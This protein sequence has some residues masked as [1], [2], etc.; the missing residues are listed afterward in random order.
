MA[1]RALLKRRITRALV[2]DDIDAEELDAWVDSATAR[3]NRSLRISEMLTHRILPLTGASFSAPSDFLEPRELRVATNPDGAVA[4]GSV[5]GPLIY[6][7]PS[8]MAAYANAEYRGGELPGYFTTRGTEIEII[9]WAVPS[10]DYQVSLWYFAKI[11]ALTTDV[12]TNVILE[13]YQD[14]Y[15]SA[16]LIYGHRFFLETESSVLKDGLVAQECAELNDRFKDAK[17]GDGPL[18]ARAPR[19]MGGRFS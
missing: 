17:Y 11:P 9:P 5:R 14:L 8:E 3:L 19:K 18:V 7:P 15:L 6:S 1:D 4:L 13:N 12:S 10:G 16:A 2:R